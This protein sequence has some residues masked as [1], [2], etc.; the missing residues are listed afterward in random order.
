MMRR[1]AHGGGGFTLVEVLMAVVLA[2]G[3]VG[4]MLLFY[5]HIGDL[6]D[7]TSDEIQKIRAR[8]LLIDRITTDLRTA[9]STGMQ[10]QAQEL[11]FT[12]AVLPGSDVWQL[13]N[14]TEAPPPAEQDIRLITYRLQ[15]VEDEDGVQ[16]VN[17]IESATQKLI[18]VQVAE[19][20][21]DIQAKLLS[22]YARFLRFR[23]W[24]G[25]TWQVEWTT[26]GLPRA[27][28]VALG[29]QPLPEGVEPVDYP[30]EMTRRVVYLPGSSG[31]RVGNVIIGPGG[32]TQ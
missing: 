3:L 21:V 32:G 5:E 10:G 30:F 19:E 1:G 23:Y 11:T 26:G 20:G 9:L 17:G 7:R 24:D 2:L 12:G 28:E 25:T 15:I 8:R 4:S 13:Q 29:E 27:V 14:I 16:Y 6:R 18:N 22:Q 31:G